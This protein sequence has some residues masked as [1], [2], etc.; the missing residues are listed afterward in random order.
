MATMMADP[1]SAG[2]SFARIPSGIVTSSVDSF[3]T[4]CR[5]E[6]GLAR[7]S[8]DAYGLDLRH[9][10]SFCRDHQ[11][12]DLE[13]IQ[14]YLDELY[15]SGLSA[16][17]VARRLTA[18]RTLYDFLLREGKIESD[19]VRLLPL[20]RQQSSL[21]KFLSTSQVDALLAAPDRKHSRGL[22]DYAMLQFL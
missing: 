10:A 19:P 15:R 6:K 2:N 1:D 20:P 14:K 22:R 18:I 9:F 12:A 8:L 11:N 17:S 4:F 13:T 21:P 3:L 16:R 7:N 5:V